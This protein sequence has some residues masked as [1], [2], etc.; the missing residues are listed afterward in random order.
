[1][2]IKSAKH[3]AQ[4]S[5][6]FLLIYSKSKAGKTTSL[7]TLEGKTLVIDTDEGM[8][9][10]DGADNI[11]YLTV[12]ESSSNAIKEIK[13]ALDLAEKNLDKYDN[14]CLDTLTALSKMILEI[15][16]VGKKDMRQ[17][18]GEMNT[19]LYPLM[20]RLEKLARQH[21]K[22]VIVTTQV[23]ATT[24]QEEQEVLAPSIEG[25]AFLNKVVLPRF[26]GI[27]ALEVDKLGKR[28]FITK[29]TGKHFAGIRDP[30]GALDTKEEAN[31]KNLFKKLKG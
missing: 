31:F 30:K 5:G 22:T 6:N 26:D 1:M 27:L 23:E 8:L 7:K 2:Q 15:H 29:P 9:S 3:V 12:N 13:E 10:L 25:K 11:D 28:K 20:R 19:T 18:Y 21:G 4:K 24:D 14:V 16:A 17:A